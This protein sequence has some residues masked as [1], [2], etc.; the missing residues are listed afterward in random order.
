MQKQNYLQL[1]AAGDTWQQQGSAPTPHLLAEDG[2]S[3]AIPPTFGKA[4]R[5]AEAQEAGA[6]QAGGQDKAAEQ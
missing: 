1:K 6:E 5:L 3:V 2:R 4:M